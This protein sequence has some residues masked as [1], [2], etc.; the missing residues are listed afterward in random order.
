RRVHSSR[1]KIG[2]GPQGSAPVERRVFAGSHRRQIHR[3]RAAGIGGGLSEGRGRRLRDWRQPKR[4]SL[5]LAGTGRGWAK[6]ARR[7]PAGAGPACR[8]AKVPPAI[9]SGRAKGLAGVHGIGGGRPPVAAGSKRRLGAPARRLLWA[10][11]FFLLTGRP[12][13]SLSARPPAPPTC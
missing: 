5:V 13:V 10:R 7:W 8:L 4:L 12:R 6:T 3:W 11:F 9:A 2:A 1:A